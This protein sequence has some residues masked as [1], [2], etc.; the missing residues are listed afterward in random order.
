MNVAQLSPSRG[1]SYI[2]FNQDSTRL[3][4]ATKHGFKIIVCDTCQSIFERSDGAI[5]IVELLFSTSLMALVGAGEHVWTCP[6][7]CPDFKFSLRIT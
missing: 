2:A 3:V 6:K 7:T 4:F 5:G 1:L